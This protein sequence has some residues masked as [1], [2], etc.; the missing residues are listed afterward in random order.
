MI[1]YDA[2]Q[3]TADDTNVFQNRLGAE[4]PR[5][6]RR[7]R[8]QLV[9][10]DSDWTFDLAVGEELA[11]DSAPSR[12]Q[13]DNIQQIDWMSPHFEFSAELARSKD[14]L[15]DVNVVTAGVGIA[16]IQWES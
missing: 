1:T 16:I 4:V 10:S 13:A 6:A 15:L 3:V 2:V 8:I 12:T 14:V 11:R 9:A 5:W 7:G